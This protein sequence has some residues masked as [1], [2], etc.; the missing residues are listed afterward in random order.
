M[1]ELGQPA[2]EGF[3]NEASGTANEY[4]HE[5]SLSHGLRSLGIDWMQEDRNG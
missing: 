1:T 4:T 2:N 3:A 5:E